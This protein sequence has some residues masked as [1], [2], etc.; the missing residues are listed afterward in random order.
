MEAAEKEHMAMLKRDSDLL[1]DKD[2]LE[3]QAAQS[4]LESCGLGSSGTSKQHNFRP[5]G[6][7]LGFD[8]AIEGGNQSDADQNASSGFEQQMVVLDDENQDSVKSVKEKEKWEEVAAILDGESSQNHEERK[9]KEAS[10]QQE[11][12]DDEEYAT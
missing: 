12:N 8:E 9:E 4:I 11:G 3:M 7:S 10:G 6:M 2:I 5:S 1:D